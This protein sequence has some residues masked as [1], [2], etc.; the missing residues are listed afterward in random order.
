MPWIYHQANGSLE[1]KWEHTG[2]RVGK[3]YSGG[4][5]AVNDPRMEA[6][7]FKG[8]IPKGN[9]HIGPMYKHPEKGPYVMNLTPVGH[10][11]RG[12]KLLRIH[13]DNENL[14]QTASEGCVILPREV[15]LRIGHSRD[16]TLQ[17]L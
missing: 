9:Y 14:N 8:P 1:Y 6:M 17:V 7:R 13:G 2:H 11:A 12:R 16:R 15:R 5:G 10:D 4:P 3:G